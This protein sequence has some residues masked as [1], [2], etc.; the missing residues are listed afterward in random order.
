M[1]KLTKYHRKRYN[2]FV[3]EKNQEFAALN[4]VKPFFS[5]LALIGAFLLGGKIGIGLIILALFISLIPTGQADD[6]TDFHK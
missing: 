5:I 6:K 1:K 4:A 2:Q 3:E